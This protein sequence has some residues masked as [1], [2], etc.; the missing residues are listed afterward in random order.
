[1][2]S[3]SNYDENRM[4][5]LLAKGSEYAFTELFSRY[6][7]KVYSV[8]F[9]FLRSQAAAEE[10]VQDVFLKCWLKREALTEV[11]NLDAY[12]KT[13]TRNL[14]LNRFRK[15]ANEAAAQQELS[16]RDI[17]VNDTDHLILDHQY[18]EIIQAALGQLP[19]QQREVY[20]LAKEEGLSHE[21]IAAR[22]QISTVTVKSHMARA[23]QSIRRYLN[24]S[25]SILLLMTLL[26]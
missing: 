20:R 1:M 2:P 17:M 9:R 7:T 3:W 8:A 15:L 12:L 19:P 24:G 23:L 11:K 26:K 6:R 5:E 16:R 25:I 10:V 22:M 4:L 14:V 21:A 18:Q 13:V